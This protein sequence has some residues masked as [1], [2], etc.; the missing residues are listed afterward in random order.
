VEL[1]TPFSFERSASTTTSN[2]AEIIADESRDILRK[3]IE[4]LRLREKESAEKAEQLRAKEEEDRL[5]EQQKQREKEKPINM[6]LQEPHPALLIP[7]PIEFEDAVL[8][9]MSHYRYGLHHW[10]IGLL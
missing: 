3:Q 1:N 8:Q 4:N 10:A 9:S 7:G 5:Q 2:A 6:S